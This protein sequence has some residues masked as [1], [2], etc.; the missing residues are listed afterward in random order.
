M[1]SKTVLDLKGVGSPLDLF[2]CKA[3]LK[4]MTEGRLLEVILAD[5]EVVQNLKLII[6]RSGDK[7]VYRKNT[8]DSICLGIKKGSRPSNQ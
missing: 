1:G 4:S 6:N 8:G 7:L 2:K 3:C 5:E